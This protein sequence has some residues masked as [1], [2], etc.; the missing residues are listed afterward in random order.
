MSG[1][2][3]PHAHIWISQSKSCV[4]TCMKLSSPERSWRPYVLLLMFIY[5][6][7]STSIL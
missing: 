1:T 3:T 6:S 7:V 4:C 2:P 5:W